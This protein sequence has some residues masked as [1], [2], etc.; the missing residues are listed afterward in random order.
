[1]TLTSH[2]L[3][4]RFSRRI[5][6]GKGGDDISENDVVVWMCHTRN[7]SSHNFHTNFQQQKHI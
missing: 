6:E 5:P 3:Y 1:M 4:E 7:T 2:Y